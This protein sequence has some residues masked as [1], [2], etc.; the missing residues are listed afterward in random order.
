MDSDKV[1]VR[2][3]RIAGVGVFAR[4][5]ISPGEVIASFDGF[6]Y[7]LE[8]PG[9]TPDLIN[10]AIQCARNWFRD[11]AGLARLV[12]HSC[13]PNCGI[14][15]LFDIVAMRVIAPGEEITWDYEMTEDSDWWRMKCRCGTAACRG[16]VGAYRNLPE[17]TRSKYKG[18][19]SEWLLDAVEPA[20]RPP[21]NDY[22][23]LRSLPIPGAVHV[24]Q[25]LPAVSAFSHGTKILPP[26]LHAAGG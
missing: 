17:S 3:S 8:Y 15:R 23:P 19:I 25:P 11:S 22:D 13:E 9:W 4:E 6:Y 2:R 10:H 24:G 26:V 16:L 20:E 12:N 18:F 14:Q 5:S 7:S 1:I 21:W